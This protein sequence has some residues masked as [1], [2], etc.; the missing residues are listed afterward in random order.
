MSAFGRKNGPAAIKTGFGVARPMHG[1][2]AKEEPRGGDQFPPLDIASLP[3]ESFDSLSAPTS[4]MQ[5]NADAMMRLSDRANAEHLPDAGPQGFEASV[6]K[7]KEQ[8][9][10]RLLERVDPEA[11]ATL[12]KDELAEEFRPIILEVLAELKLTLNRREQFALEKV[13]VDELLGLGPLEELLND[14]DI[15]D[16]MVNG[17]DQTYI[18]KKGKLVIAPIKF[19]DEEHL[20]QIAQ[21]IVN[22][23]GRRVDQTTPLAD[24]RLP[25]GSR[26]NVIVPPLSLKG[27]AI[28]IRKFSAKPIT[29]DMLANWGAMSP[30]M[31]TAL[32]IA[33]AC[34]FNIVISGGT[35]SGK[36]TMLNALSKMIDPGERVLTIEDAAELRLQQPHWLPLETRPANLEGNGAIT[37][38][39]LVKNALRMRPDRIILGEIRGA[40]CFD[41]LAAMNTG[42]DGSMCTLHANSPRECLGRMEN[43][44]LM[45]DIKIPKE[46]ISKQI[47]DSVDLIIQVKRLRDGSRRITNVTEVI[48]MEG[49]VIVT[50]ELFKFEYHD[51]DDSGKIVGEYR[52]MGLRPYT[53]DKARMFG[54]DQPF[55]E[56]CL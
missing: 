17:P 18:E 27:T 20:F 29:L 24:A 53:L 31:A 4:Q 32:K 34:R 14:P 11:A 6:H 7:I 10:P 37:I 15:T 33:G 46:A 30:K 39:D 41:L 8:V 52:S 21:R 55:L 25:D 56:A 40:E 26:V 47:A 54:F 1:G 38:G 42:H 13:L 43:M 9:L 3:G 5:R 19:R 48:G 16:I 28:S 2:S 45:G 23:V 36:T 44:I 22:K 50:Q 12:T 35:G 51:E 49:D